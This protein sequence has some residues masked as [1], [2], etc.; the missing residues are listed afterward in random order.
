MK[1]SL[2]LTGGL[3]LTIVQQGKC[4]N[5]DFLDATMQL[6]QLYLCSM[7]S[8]TVGGNLCSYQH[9]DITPQ[10]GKGRRELHHQHGVYLLLLH[11]GSQFQQESSSG[12]RYHIHV[13]S[14]QCSHQLICT[15]YTVFST[16][17]YHWC[18]DKWEYHYIAKT[19]QP[20]DCP[21]HLGAHREW[22]EVWG[23]CRST[24]LTI[25]IL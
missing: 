1:I 11:R 21:S 22:C 10:C 15:F 18:S 17:P 13:P 7:F 14:L 20:R 19:C 5:T 9:F 8:A 12:F 3:L 16:K 4:N 24:R 23:E 25:N 2:F 6:V